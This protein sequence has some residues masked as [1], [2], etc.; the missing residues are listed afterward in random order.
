MVLKEYVKIKLYTINSLNIKMKKNKKLNKVNIKKNNFCNKSK[1]Y[2]V[3][4]LSIT[5]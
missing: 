3:F 5:I 2:Y 1:N 4:Y